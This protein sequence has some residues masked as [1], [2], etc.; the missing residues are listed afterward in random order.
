MNSMEFEKAAKWFCKSGRSCKGLKSIGLF[1]LSESV[2]IFE[3]MDGCIKRLSHTH[4]LQVAKTMIYPYIKYTECIVHNSIIVA[5]ICQ[6]L[7]I[8]ANICN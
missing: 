5:K 7:P 4:K 3:W 1:V 2:V 6:F 8:V